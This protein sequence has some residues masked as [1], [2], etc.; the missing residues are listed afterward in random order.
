MNHPI[1]SKTNLLI[2][3][4]VELFMK[5]QDTIPNGYNS[6][7]QSKDLVRLLLECAMV[8]TAL[9]RRN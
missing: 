2:F 5:I 8:F 7:S 4:N 3:N 9:T 1:Q 6:D